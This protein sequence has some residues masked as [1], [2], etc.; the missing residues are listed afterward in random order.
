MQIAIFRAIVDDKGK[1]RP[2][3]IDKTDP[4]K[5]TAPGE[6]VKFTDTKPLTILTTIGYNS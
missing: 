1:Q 3:K 5:Y 2:G 6:P 4:K